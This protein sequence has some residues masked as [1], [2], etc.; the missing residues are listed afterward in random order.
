MKADANRNNGVL[1]PEQIR[2]VR[3]TM[4]KYSKYDKA[5]KESLTYDGSQ[6]MQNMRR[7]I[8][9]TAKDHIP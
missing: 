7:S 3:S 1:T 6:L 8:D 5:D 9:N 4:S 2:T